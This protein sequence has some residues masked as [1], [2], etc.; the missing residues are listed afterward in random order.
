MAN[1]NGTSTGIAVGSGSVL[2]V[3][4]YLLLSPWVLQPFD[5]LGVAA[6]NILTGILLTLLGFGWA[7]SF[8][9]LRAITWIAPVLGAWVICVPWVGEAVQA[10]FTGSALGAPAWTGNIVAGGVAIAAGILLTV[11]AVRGRTTS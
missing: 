11:L 4:L 10:G 6:S 1:R 8:E 5:Q 2:L 9:R 7:R 3:G